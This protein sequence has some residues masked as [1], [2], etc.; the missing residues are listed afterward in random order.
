MV[1]D[2]AAGGPDGGQRLRD[3]SWTTQSK[4]EMYDATDRTRSTGLALENQHV[5]AA[6]SLS[7]NEVALFVDRNDP[8]DILVKP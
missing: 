3:V 8:K 6:R 7:L 1:A 2:R 5:P 4:P